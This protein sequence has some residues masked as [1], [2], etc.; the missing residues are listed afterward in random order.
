MSIGGGG[1]LPRLCWE[2]RGRGGEEGEG[3]EGRGGGGGVRCAPG[4]MLAVFCMSPVSPVT[5]LQTAVIVT[6]TTMTKTEP[7]AQQNEAIYPRFQSAS[8]LVLGM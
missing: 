2:L 1:G 7:A 5:T 4:P 3:G 8:V 6:M